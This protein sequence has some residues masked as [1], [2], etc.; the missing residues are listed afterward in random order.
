MNEKSHARLKQII[1]YSRFLFKFSKVFP[2]I[3]GKLF[4][5][6]IPQQA[7]F[8]NKFSPLPLSRT[9]VGMNHA[10]KSYFKN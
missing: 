1:I 6:A 2:K 9:R 5:E 7:S 3:W 10:L 4:Q 8:Q